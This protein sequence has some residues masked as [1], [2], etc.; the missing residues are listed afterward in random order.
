MHGD[1]AQPCCQVLVRRDAADS[2]VQLQEDILGHFFCCSTIAED[3]VRDAVDARLMRFYDLSKLECAPCHPTSSQS[4]H[5]DIRKRRAAG[6][7]VAIFI[8]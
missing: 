1:P 2:P 3:A 8:F 6:M 5:S 7:Q 4:R